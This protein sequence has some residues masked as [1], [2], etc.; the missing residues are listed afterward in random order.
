M[1]A[2]TFVSRI[3]SAG[4]DL[5]VSGGN[6]TITPASQ[7]TDSQRQFIKT[8]KPAIL[9]HLTGKASGPDLD[10]PATPPDPINPTND[11][12]LSRLLSLPPGER[13][14]ALVQAG[15]HMDFEGGRLV[16]VVKLADIE[17]DQ[18][19]TGRGKP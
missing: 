3:R 4:F 6:L 11:P 15:Y 8:H 7:L 12:E 14:V 2:S 9:A 10:P 16:R 18:G 1:D 17:G 5:A 13:L 19:T